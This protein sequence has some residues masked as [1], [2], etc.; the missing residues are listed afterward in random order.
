MW[1][2]IEESKLCNW[3]CKEDGFVTV[4]VWKYGNTA[5]F[6]MGLGDDSKGL[7]GMGA[8]S[9]CMQEGTFEFGHIKP[10]CSTSHCGR[11]EGQVQGGS[12]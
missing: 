9:L 7:N 2:C 3:S 10:L 4:G 5:A 11:E 12:M 1:V 6:E 8:R